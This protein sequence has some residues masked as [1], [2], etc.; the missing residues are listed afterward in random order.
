LA[1]LIINPT[2][3][4]KKEIPVT[5]KIV[6]IGRDP[7]NDLV[8]SDAMVSRRH[9]ILERRGE[10][11]VLRDNASSN[12]T[13]VNGD[14]V[15]SEQ[16]LRDGDLIAIGSARLLFSAE[17]SAGVPS[18]APPAG[19]LNTQPMPIQPVPSQPPGAA[20]RSGSPGLSCLACGAQALPS[21]WREIARL[22]RQTGGMQELRGSS[23]ASRE[24]LWCLWEGALSRGSAAGSRLVGGSTSSSVSGGPVGC[25]RSARTVRT[26]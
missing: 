15:V 8:L 24:V 12:G 19:P 1:K 2:S 6:S 20:S 21:M 10:Q 11:F 14:R 25:G 4:A 23:D 18:L 17:N 16:P 26:R 9:A 13:M 5:G 3:G 7:S 22:L